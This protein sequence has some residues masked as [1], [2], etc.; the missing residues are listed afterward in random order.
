MRPNGSPED[1]KTRR[2]YAARLLSQG[3]SQ[4]EVASIL[5][6]SRSS[7]HRWNQTLTESGMKGLNGKKHAGP[8][9]KLSVSQRAEL[10][11]LV[12]TGALMYNHRSCETYGK[13]IVK[14][15]QRRYG[16]TYHFKS[17]GRLLW[18]LGL[19]SYGTIPRRSV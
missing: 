14:E 18:S 9:P 16:V 6:A 12:S 3:M 2:R 10:K 8:K 7:V 13:E 4:S 5:D 1:L 17:I 15:I 11:Q 19:T